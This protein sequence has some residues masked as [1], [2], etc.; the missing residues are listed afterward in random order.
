MFLVH[1]SFHCTKF[2]FPGNEK[3]KRADRYWCLSRQDVIEDII[4]SATLSTGLVAY[5]DFGELVVK[6]LSVRYLFNK[7]HYKCDYEEKW[8]STW[9]SIGADNVSICMTNTSF[10]INVKFHASGNNLWVL[11]G[12]VVKPLLDR[13]FINLLCMKNAGTYWSTVSY[14]KD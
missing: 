11:Y 9:Y 1:I 7:T 3:L 8:A 2:N 10:P 14:L 4:K 5:E 13:S 12:I 6:P